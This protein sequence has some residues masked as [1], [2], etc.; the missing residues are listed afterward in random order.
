MV[1]GV[2]LIFCLKMNTNIFYK[3]IVS[4]WIC[5]ARHAQSTQNKLTIYFQYLMENMKNELDFLHAD[6]CQRFPQTAIIIL[7]VRG[8]ACPNHPE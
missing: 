4:L 1:V 6:E 8:Q 2:K 5:V 7:V 3:L